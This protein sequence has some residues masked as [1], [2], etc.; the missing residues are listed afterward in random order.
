M[1]NGIYVS[2]APYR[3]STAFYGA[4]NGLLRSAANHTFQKPTKQPTNWG[5]TCL[6]CGCILVVGK[7]TET[8]KTKRKLAWFAVAVVKMSKS[9][10]IGTTLTF[11]CVSAA[12]KTGT[13]KLN[14]NGVIWTTGVKARNDMWN[15]FF[16]DYY[17]IRQLGQFVNLP[18]AK[19]FAEEWMCGWAT[20]EDEMFALNEGLTIQ[21]PDGRVFGDVVS[22]SPTFL[23]IG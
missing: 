21:A 13:M 11:Q 15:L 10:I 9:E 16:E 14:T 4:L 12:G 22:E 18:T 2:E 8:W 3:L 20:C 23:Y 17:G 7:E 5:L 1:R 6:A 19:E